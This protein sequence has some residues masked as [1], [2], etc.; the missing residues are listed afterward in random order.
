MKQKFTSTIAGASIFISVLGLLSRGL[1]FLREMLFASYFGLGTD[2]DLYL[3]GAVLPV[4][5]NSIIFYIGQNF[6]VPGFQ[7][8]NSSKHEEVQKFYNQSFI[9]FLGVGSFITL[10]LF[11]AAD[12]IIYLYVHSSPPESIATASRVFRIFLLTVPISAGISI[13]SALLQTVYEFKYNPISVLFLNISVIVLMFFFTNNLGIYVIPFGYVIGTLIQFCYLFIKSRKY[14]RFNLFSYFRQF[15]QIKSLLGS[16]LVIILLIESVGQ[17]YSIFDRYFY[18]YVNPGGIASINYAYTIYA[19]PIVVFSIALATAVFPKITQAIYNSSNEEAEKIYIES[20]SVNIL[21]FM[22]LTFVLFF[23]G[24]VLVTIAFER[25]KFIS[26]S[27]SITY[28][29]LKCYSVSLVFYSV[30]TV[31]NKMFFSLNLAKILLIITVIGIFLKFLL[32]FLLVEKYQQYGLASSTSLT[33]FFFFA[34]SYVIINKKLKVKDKTAFM[35]E[36]CICVVNS[37]I[38][39]LIV[40]FLLHLI[41]ISNIISDLVAI[42]FFV[43]IYFMNLLLLKYKSMILIRHVFQRVYPFAIANTT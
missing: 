16:S 25:G 23:Y 27:T 11:L 3:V 8:I 4:T 40:N 42:A 14:F 29:A 31:L 13:L 1:G 38:S 36:F 39:I 33:Y 12:P 6:F 28:N 19:L 2:F 32:N 37:C 22:P 24:E 43:I 10:I 30:Y 5:I 20:T 15:G 26:E 18:G 9:L 21:I 7:K 41:T 34:V 17:L 35:K